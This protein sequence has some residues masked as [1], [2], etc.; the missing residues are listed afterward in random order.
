MGMFPLLRPFTPTAPE[1]AFNRRRAWTSMFQPR[2]IQRR[3]SSDRIGQSPGDKKPRSVDIDIKEAEKANNKHYR[4]EAIKA[5]RQAQLKYWHEYV[6]PLRS[7]MQRDVEVARPESEA[8]EIDLRQYRISNGRYLWSDPPIFIPNPVPKRRISVT[9]DR[10]YDSRIITEYQPTNDELNGLDDDESS[11]EEEDDEY[12]LF[13]SE[14][15]Y[16]FMH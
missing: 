12:P 14:R 10:T 5:R 1:L 9:G 7:S 13:I 2:S 4:N 15:D 3:W 8:V 16:Y 6:E 11:L